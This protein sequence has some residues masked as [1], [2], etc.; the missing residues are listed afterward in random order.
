[1]SA[2]IYQYKGDQELYVKNFSDGLD[3]IVEVIKIRCDE[4]SLGTMISPD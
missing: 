3:K 4:C 1:M 2:G